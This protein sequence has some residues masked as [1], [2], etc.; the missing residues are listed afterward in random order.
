M[1]KKKVR[2]SASPS[3]GSFFGLAIVAGEGL[4]VLVHK[5]V[6]FRLLLLLFAAAV[7]EEYHQHHQQRQ[8]RQREDQRCDTA[9]KSEYELHCAQ[10]EFQHHFNH[11]QG[12][13]EDPAQ[14]IDHRYFLL[15][16]RP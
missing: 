9:Q 10:G 11:I 2:E 14:K 6:A 1:V 4:A 8:P 13:F 5:D 15:F 7:E 3:Q 12:K 16:C